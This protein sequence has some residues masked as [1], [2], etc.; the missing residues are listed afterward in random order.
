MSSI[1]EKYRGKGAQQTTSA[2]A[3][4]SGS[5]LDKYRGGTTREEEAEPGIVGQAINKVV[6]AVPEPVRTTVGT[7]LN[8]VGRPGAAAAGAIAGALSDEEGVE[9]SAFKRGLANLTGERRDDFDQVLEEQGFEDSFARNAAGFVGDVVVDPLNL[10]GVGAVKGAIKAG[11]KAAATPLAKGLAAADKATGGIG[12]AVVDDLGEKFVPRYGLKVSEQEAE[13]LGKVGKTVAPGGEVADEFRKFTKERSTIPTRMEKQAFED[14]KQFPDEA[15]R[16]TVQDDLHA[17]AGSTPEIDQFVQKQ[18]IRQDE[19]FQ[20]E[21]NAKVQK[22]ENYNP[23]YGAF[24]DFTAAQQAGKQIPGMHPQSAL[25]AKLGPAKARKFEN[26]QDAKAAGAEPDSAVAWYHRLVK[27][28][29]AILTS[30]HAQQMAAKYGIK[31]E[32]LTNLNPA[33]IATFRKLEKFPAESPLKAHL[34]EYVFP[35][36]IAKALD[37]EFTP[38][39]AQGM[40]GRLYDK[41]MDAW[42]TQATVLRPAFHATNMQGNIF[43]AWLGGQVN[44][45]RFV[46][47]VAWAVGKGP[48]KIGNYTRDQIDDY[49]SRYAVGGADHN[50]VGDTLSV[51]AETNLKRM[52]AQGPSPSAGQKVTNAV[53]HPIQ[54]ARYVG[55]SLEDASKRAL[56]FDG[57]HKG[58]SLDDAAQNVDKFLFDYA[59]LTQFERN[60]MKK[61]FPF[62]TWMRK[63]TPL[64]AE[65][66][67][68]QPHKLAAVS[69]VQ[70]SLEQASDEKGTRLDPALRP[71]YLQKTGAIQLPTEKGQNKKFWT[72][73][74]PYQDLD[75]LPI[76]GGSD[77]MSVLRDV[78]SGTTP[79]AK[80]AV[81]LLTNKSLFT[82]KPLYDSEL[83]PVRDT[84]PIDPLMAMLPD[85][86]KDQLFNETKGPDGKPRHEE[87]ALLKYILQ[88]ITPVG[89]NIGKAAQAITDPENASNPSAHIGQLTGVRINELSKKQEDATRKAALSETKRVRDKERKQQPTKKANVDSLY[90][91]Y[92]GGK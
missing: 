63:N 90:D 9:G 58:M 86:V 18:H 76:P 35:E 62:Y 43:N 29:K 79:G 87:A 26:W 21:M 45:G 13:T 10:L 8:Y 59:D 68:T 49:M 27:S 64:Q 24:Q 47:S 80:M 37:A 81:E 33:D 28:E 31:V 75:K 52:L 46:E 48:A 72:P 34:E 83:G 70:N 16:A 85:A 23:D 17:G 66:L 74:L 51:G 53:K 32:E 61:V 54:T 56:F 6:S 5:V 67:V 92:L 11:T 44:P 69:K 39:K 36:R 20:R 84:Q 71:E 7:V 40:L 1:L 15:T 14:F 60:V 55:S 2:P 82:N 89:Q 50:L 88:N 22:P 73:Y 57:L 78:A 4:R 25:N 12:K 38:G 30:E 42:R 19:M 77:V 65:A 3:P 91:R 41:A